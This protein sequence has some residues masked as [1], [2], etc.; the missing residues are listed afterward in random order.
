[1]GRKNQ[2]HDRDSIAGTEIAGSIAKGR[3]D[4]GGEV[5]LGVSLYCTESL[6]AKVRMKRAFRKILR[7]TQGE[8]ISVRTPK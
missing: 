1:M 7:A 6:D 4:S 5:L 8:E 3:K 2:K